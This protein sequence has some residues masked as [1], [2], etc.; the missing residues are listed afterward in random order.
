MNDYLIRLVIWGWLAWMVG[1]VLYAA[2]L[3]GLY[4]ITAREGESWKR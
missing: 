1:A 4:A 3:A 2:A